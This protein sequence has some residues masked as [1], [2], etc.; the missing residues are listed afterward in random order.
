MASRKRPSKGLPSAGRYPSRHR[1]TP[2]VYSPSLADDCQTR[3]PSVHAESQSDQPAEEAN[4]SPPPPDSDSEDANA[5]VGRDEATA[6]A[7]SQ[8]EATTATAGS[9]GTTETQPEG[10]SAAVASDA[11]GAGGPSGGVDQSVSAADPHPDGEAT[12]APAGS[13]GTTR[14]DEDAETNEVASDASRFGGGAGGPSG[15]VSAAVPHPDGEATTA[16]A[17]S[18]GTTRQDEDA[19]TNEEE[20]D[21]NNEGRASV[22]P[23]EAPSSR[24]SGSGPSVSTGQETNGMAHGGG[25]EAGASGAIVQEGGGGAHVF[26]SV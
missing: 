21:K 11:G 1:Q 9:E 18:E 2:V 17:G 4:P 10:S 20:G 14:Q 12:T 7:R 15:A 24:G 5:L 6:H 22:G 23:S 25:N 3:R 8:S 26:L 13:E 19:E 16:P